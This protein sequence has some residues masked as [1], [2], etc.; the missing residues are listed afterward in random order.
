MIPGTSCNRKRICP[1]HPVWAKA[2]EAMLNV[3]NTAT[4]AELAVEAKNPKQ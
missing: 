3:L 1:A 4:I 2:Q